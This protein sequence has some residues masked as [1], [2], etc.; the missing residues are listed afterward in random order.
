VLSVQSWSWVS[1]LKQVSQENHQWSLKGEILWPVW[2]PAGVAGHSGNHL[3]PISPKP[4]KLG[5]NI[6]RKVEKVFPQ[7][8]GCWTPHKTR[9]KCLAPYPRPE[10][11][12]QESSLEMEAGMWGPS[13]RACSLEAV[14]GSILVTQDKEQGPGTTQY[15][16]RRQLESSFLI[17]PVPRTLLR[18]VRALRVNLNAQELSCVYR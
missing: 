5:K 11:R 13:Q 18:E 3:L 15:Q 16:G 14:L 2:A 8:K 1:E 17:K 12:G 9:R 7:R 4:I 6:E 10:N